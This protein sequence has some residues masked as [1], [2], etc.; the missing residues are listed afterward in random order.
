MVLKNRTGG[1][2]VFASSSQFNQVFDRFWAFLSDRTGAR[3]LV[4]P[5][6]LV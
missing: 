1:K 2:T 5:V 3:F 6:G 4:E